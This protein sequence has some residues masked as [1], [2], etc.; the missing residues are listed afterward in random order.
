[1]I[2][3]IKV[4]FQE[5]VKRNIMVN[6]VVLG[7]IVFDMI[8]G[9]DEVEL[10]KMV[11]VNCFGKLEE[12]VYLVSFFVLQKVVYIIGEVININGGIYV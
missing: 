12:V 3:F 8:V 4:L 1:M 9:F 10:K 11:L 5:V 6:V 7:F 2:V